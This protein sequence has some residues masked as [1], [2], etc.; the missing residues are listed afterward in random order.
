MDMTSLQE[1]IYLTER[2]LAQMQE[3][4]E[5]IPRA[6]SG[7]V[8]MA[9]LKGS[10]QAEEKARLLKRILVDLQDTAARIL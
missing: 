2:L 3:D 5:N 6:I 10:E 9:Y 4:R 7:D 1:S 8:L